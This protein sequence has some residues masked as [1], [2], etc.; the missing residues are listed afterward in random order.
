MFGIEEEV[1]RFL[2][3]Q[4]VRINPLN[5]P[6]VAKSYMAHLHQTCN[7]WESQAL[8]EFG[9]TSPFVSCGGREGVWLNERYC[10]GNI[11]S[12]VRDDRIIEGM[13]PF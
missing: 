8:K 4:I 9:L 3:Q 10:H 11:K 12:K 7:K 13:V 2:V 5:W 6:L 1:W